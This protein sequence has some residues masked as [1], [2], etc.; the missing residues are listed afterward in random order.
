MYRK[1]RL[2][3]EGA[4]KR[5]RLKSVSR[6]S[7]LPAYLPSKFQRIHLELTN[8]CNFSC[9]F[10]PD[11]V[12]TR[13]RG[14]MD[15]DLARSALDQIADLDIA[16]KVTLH[17]MGEPLLHPRFFEILDYAASR[18]L[19]V[20]LTTNGALLSPS[21]IQRLAAR[22]LHQIDI[23]LQTP[24]PESFL[25]TRGT[26]MDFHKYK[27]RVLELLSACAD[28]P[29]PP[30]FKIRIMTT[31]FAS[32]LCEK[33]GIPNFM[34]SS[35]KLRETI[36]EWTE[37]VHQRL[38][39]PV[40]RERLIKKINKISIHGWN[41]IEISPKIFIETY[42]LTDWG[43]A[44]AGEELVEN[45]RGYCFGMRDHFA[46]LHTGDVVLCCVD[47]DGRTAVGNL[48]N[49]S[50]LD[51]LRSPELERIVKGFHRG[52]LLD[53]HCRHCLG[54]SSRIGS[55]V[56]PA[57]S[58]IGLKFLKPFFYRKHR[59]FDLRRSDRIESS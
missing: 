47:F 8:K 34:G 18:N 52:I 24:D 42:I 29:K 19:A 46:I 13:E 51:I 41:V 28:S 50:L 48:K 20:G 12:M 1:F 17:V 45:R 57:A 36:L 15:E 27:D 3:L 40:E 14:V 30:I 53:P 25:A 44:F 59:L 39:S 26:R 43:N 7:S 9:V 23:S 31:R 10:C 58:I 56:K 2:F 35:A 49:A 6:N 33:R 11:G 4:R 37:L 21:I 54:S 16:E 22:G 32:G 55:W 38:G 5:F